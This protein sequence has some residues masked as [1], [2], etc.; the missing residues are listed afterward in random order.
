MRSRFQRMMGC[1]RLFIAC[2][3]LQE[4]FPRLN[5]RSVVAQCDRLQP[6]LDTRIVTTIRRQTP[7]DS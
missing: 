3:L 6:I 2:Q 5:R 7:V 4:S 1:D